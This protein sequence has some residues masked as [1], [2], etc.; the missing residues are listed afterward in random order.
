[1]G[2]T[3]SATEKMAELTTAYDSVI[4]LLHSAYCS[5]NTRRKAESLLAD[6][7]AEINQLRTEVESATAA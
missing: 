1:V 2:R 6:L 5:E 3:M 7:A 4:E